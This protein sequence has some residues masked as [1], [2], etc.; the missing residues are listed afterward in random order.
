MPLIN[1]VIVSHADLG[2]ALIRAA[3]MIVGPTEGLYS[4]ALLPDN[5]PE[6]FGEKLEAALQAIEGQDTLVL[7]DL[8]GGTPCNVAACQV[9]KENVACVTGANLPMLLELIMS[10][11][12]ALLSELAEDIT[13][14]G[15]ESVRNLGPMLRT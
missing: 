8:L 9:L 1:I 15:Q 4:I 12:D 14:A 5:S 13:Q 2:D 10:R 3:E 11:D 7:I 6:G